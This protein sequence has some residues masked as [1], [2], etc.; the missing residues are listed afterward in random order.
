MG[1]PSISELRGASRVRCHT[2]LRA[3]RQASTHRLNPSHKAGTRFTYPGGMESWVDHALDYAPAGNRTHDRLIESLNRS[4]HCATKTSM[5]PWSHKVGNSCRVE[6]SGL[7]EGRSEKIRATTWPARKDRS[8]SAPST[9]AT[10]FWGRTKYTRS[11]IFGRTC[12]RSVI[13]EAIGQIRRVGLH[14]LQHVQATSNWLQRALF[15]TASQ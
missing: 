2:I 6:V 10:H 9:S 4:N 11:S 1:K 8:H 5:Q 14:S 15:G 13:N 12:S 3:A 7:L